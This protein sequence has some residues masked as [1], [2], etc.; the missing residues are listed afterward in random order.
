MPFF[1]FVYSFL[2]PSEVVAGTGVH[3]ELNG[4]D[5]T[6]TERTENE[7]AELKKHIQISEEQEKV[8]RNI[9]LSMYKYLESSEPVGKRWEQSLQTRKRKLKEVVGDESYQQMNKAGLINRWFGQEQNQ[10][11]GH[12]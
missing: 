8:I 6:S 7:M 1:A 5:T 11:I 10:L 9:F 2:S 3:L 12:D 4:R